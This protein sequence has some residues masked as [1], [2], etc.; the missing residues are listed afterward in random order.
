MGVLRERV[1]T[2]EYDVRKAKQPLRN[3]QALRR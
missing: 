2:G 3:K 1:L